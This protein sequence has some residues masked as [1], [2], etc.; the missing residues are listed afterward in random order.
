MSVVHAPLYERDH[1]GYAYDTVATAEPSATALQADTTGMLAPVMIAGQRLRICSKF[2]ALSWW[3][4]AA[5]SFL[6]PLA[7]QMALDELLLALHQ[8]PEGSC[9]ACRGRDGEHEHVTADGTDNRRLPCTDMC[10]S[11]FTV[12]ACLIVFLNS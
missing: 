2:D 9:L 12:H 10:R 1:R 6:D 5:D 7:N 4:N 11:G 8:L 3:P